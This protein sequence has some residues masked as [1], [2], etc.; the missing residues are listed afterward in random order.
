MIRL[1]KMANCKNLQNELSQFCSTTSIQVNNL[2]N[3][4]GIGWERGGGAN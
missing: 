4:K 3:Y 2:F 1:G